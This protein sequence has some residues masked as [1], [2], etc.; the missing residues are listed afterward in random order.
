MCDYKKISE[1]GHASLKTAMMRSVVCDT[2]NWIEANL[3]S[4]LH[5]EQLAS[6]AGYTRW[7]FQRSFKKI[8]GQS[9]SEY[10]RIRRIVK[11]TEAIIHT[12]ERMVDIAYDSGYSN[13]QLM[14][15]LIRATFGMSPTEL[16]HCASVCPCSEIIGQQVTTLKQSVLLTN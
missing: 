10:V 7:H 1:E 8:T 14:S 6:R 2:L 5:I 4:D 13:Q 16:R 9:L 15:R 12:R 11:A 3:H